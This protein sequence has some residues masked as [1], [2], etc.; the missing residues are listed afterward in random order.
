MTTFELTQKPVV[1]RAAGLVAMAVII[2]M[3]AGCN[4]NYGS[5]ARSGQVGQAF[6]SGDHQADY[7]YFYSGRDNMPYAIIG[8]DRSYTVPSRYWIAFE[9]ESEK[10]KKMSDN[11]FGK[12]RYS[13]TGLHI[14]DP[15]GKIIGVWFSSVI[16]HSVSVDQENRTVEVLFDNPENGRGFSVGWLGH[17]L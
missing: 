4:K 15:E 6:L 9:A 17:R 10:L 13:P 2:L 12:H 5:F 14:L 11:M 8:I 16:S 7:Q 3:V 1:A